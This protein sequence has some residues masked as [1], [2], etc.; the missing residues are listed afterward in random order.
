[1]PLLPSVCL[2]VLSVSIP[3]QALTPLPPP[4]K[5][6]YTRSVTWHNYLGVHLG[7]GP[8]KVPP[9]CTIFITHAPEPAPPRGPGKGAGPALPGVRGSYPTLMTLGPAILTTTG[10]GEGITTGPLHLTA[11]A[12]GW[13]TWTPFQG[14]LYCAAWA[15]C[16]ACSPALL[17]QGASFS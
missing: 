16:R 15:R 13:L 6:L 17:T 14:Q 5:S 8:P 9:N 1:M 2:H 11:D 12:W 4:S 10:G 7:I 3:S